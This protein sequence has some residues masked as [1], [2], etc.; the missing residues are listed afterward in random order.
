MSAPPEAG[1]ND[2]EALAKRS[3][4]VLGGLR[5]SFASLE[6]CY[7]T[8]HARPWWSPHGAFLLRARHQSGRSG[9]LCRSGA[10]QSH[11]PGARHGWHALHLGQR[12]TP[13]PEGGAGPIDGRG[14]HRRR[15]FRRRRRPSG[16]S[17]ALCAERHRPRCR[18][19]TAGCR[20]VQSPR[21]SHRSAR[22]H[23]DDRWHGN[24]CV[25]RR[26]RSRHRCDAQWPPGR[27]HRPRGQHLRRRHV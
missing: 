26:R 14:R 4:R 20:H 25:H 16:A 21:P 1:Q 7:Y 6:A 18:G 13:D 12:H 27:R 19:R 22:G 9:R 23:Y 2:V 24:G 5:R 3:L 15:R 8:G 17:A 10:C 11:R